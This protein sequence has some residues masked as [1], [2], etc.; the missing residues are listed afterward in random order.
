MSAAGYKKLKDFLGE[1]A[2]V[3]REL[4]TKDACELIL[5]NTPREMGSEE[6]LEEDKIERER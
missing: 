3:M 4:A 1:D 2:R 6:K 5:D